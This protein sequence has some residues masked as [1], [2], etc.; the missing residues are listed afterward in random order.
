MPIACAVYRR[1]RSWRLV[2]LD[3]DP[4]ALA[5]YPVEDLEALTIPVCPIVSDHRPRPRIGRVTSGIEEFNSH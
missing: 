5:G 1:R 2:R 3:C 4:Q